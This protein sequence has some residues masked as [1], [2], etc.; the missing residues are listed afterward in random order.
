M[1]S[2]AIPRKRRRASVISALML[3]IAFALFS[4]TSEPPNPTSTPVPTPA[5]VLLNSDFS[6]AADTAMA[7]MPVSFYVDDPVEEASYSW[8][9]GDGSSAVGAQSEHTYL[10]AGSFTVRLSATLGSQS[11]RSQK[12]VTVQPGAAGWIVVDTEAVSLRSGQRYLFQAD[13]YDELGNRIPDPDI[14]WSADPSAGSI[15]SDGAFTAGAEIGFWA[16]GVTARLERGGT[17]AET[18]L[19]VEVVYDALTSIRVEPESVLTRVTW[20]L[21]LNAAALDVAGR[22]IEEA[23]IAWEVLRRGDSIDQTGF[24]TPGESVSDVDEALLLVQ[25]SYDGKQI[26]HIVR[27]T[28]EPGIL[29]RIEI[30]GSL[31]DITAGDTVPLSARGF[32]RF[33]HGLEL[34]KLEWRVNDDDAGYITDEGLFTAGTLAAEFDDTAIEARGFKDGIQTFGYIPITVK[35]SAAVSIEFTH[36]NDS[37]PAGSGAPIDLRV[38]DAHGNKITDIDVYVEVN[39]GGMLQSGNVFKAGFEEGDF[40]DAIIARILPQA[41]GNDQEIKTA[42]DIQVRRRSSDFIAVEIA[43]PQNTVVYLINLATSELIPLSPQMASGDHSSA[44]PAW[45]PDGSRIAFAYDIG[46]RFQIYDIDPFRNDMRQITA[47][48]DGAI[49]PAISPDGSKIAFV[50][51]TGWAWQIELADLT[52]DRDGQLV[53]LNSNSDNMIR[54]SQSDEHRHLRPIFSPDGAW[55]MFTSVDADG[56]SVV[57]LVDADDP[58]ADKGLELRGAFGMDWH[59]H[60]HSLLLLAELKGS[61]VGE[62]ASL[63]LYDLNSSQVTPLDTGGNGIIMAA[64][65]PDGTE[66]VFAGDENSGMWLSDTDASGLR[67]GLSSRYRPSMADWR[68]VEL[69]LPTPLERDLGS[70]SLTLPSGN[71]SRDRYASPGQLESGPFTVVLSTGLGEIRIDLYNHLAPITVDNFINLVNQGYYDG[72]AFH[73]VKPGSAVFTG[74]IV[75]SFGGTAGYYI[76]SEYHLQ[77]RHDS[78]GIVS[79]VTRGENMASSEFAIALAPKP[80]WDAFDENG[81]KNCKDPETICYTV[82]GKVVEG[83]NILTQFE[84]IDRYS[85]SV[86]PH[87]ILKARLEVTLPN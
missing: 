24:Y 32:D 40:P 45:W 20:D 55:I 31:T 56:N 38:S 77:A 42:T 36:P 48:E 63:F 2:H 10:D 70:T 87:R 78:P 82:F 28:I 33:G 61:P 74:S 41:S 9:F 76:P 34:D 22:V 51:T 18:K 4:C 52:F 26:Q 25:A 11:S 85:S 39:S 59:P 60:G 53:A 15:D 57:H 1:D 3:A 71:I 6:M 64:L 54:I 7:P 58:S 65:S 16:S 30:E 46:G 27:G 21:D 12:S 49:M 62:S 69:V 5:P 44:T 80:E 23:E 67:Q 8:D 29:D 14:E 19:D 35:P 83:L 84:E 81:P 73:T 37:I 17:T 75:D 72:L 47:V 86:S 68:P 13:A 43:G 79:M 50:Q 66:F